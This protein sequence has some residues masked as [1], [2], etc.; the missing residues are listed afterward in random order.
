M[1]MMGQQTLRRLCRIAAVASMLV[2]VA[3]G[4]VDAAVAEQAWE[5]ILRL[6]LQDE[7]RCQLRAIVSLR[8]LEIGGLGGLE[9]RIR[10]ADGREF[11]FSRQKAH[12]KF[13]LRLCQPAVC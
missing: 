13:E 7:R 3:V 12:Q 1:I 8:D 2:A 10:C 5:S 11:D 4:T 6:Q 9:G